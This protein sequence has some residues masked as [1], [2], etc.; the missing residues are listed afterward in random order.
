MVSEPMKLDQICRSG[1]ESLPRGKLLKT[2]V[3]SRLRG[4]MILAPLAWGE[5]SHED[6]RI[7][8]R[9]ADVDWRTT[10]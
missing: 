3:N 2:T 8:Q 5:Y 10:T 7:F 1:T 9:A 4:T 6:G